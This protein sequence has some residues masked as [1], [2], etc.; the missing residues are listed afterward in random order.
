[1]NIEVTNNERFQ[2]HVIN[3]VIPFPKMLEQAGFDDYSYDGKCY[4]PFHDNFDT[5][6]AKIYHDSTGDTLWCFS[7]QKRYYPAD[8]LKKGMI[9]QKSVA[10]IFN[11]LWGKLSESDRQELI[12]TY[13]KPLDPTP[14]IWKENEQ[15]LQLFKNGKLNVQTHI[16]LMRQCL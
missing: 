5:P 15:K 3:H 7:E 11:R 6:A 4:C 12:N 9:K 2:A 16:E 1:M 14:E 8:V 13:D 10:S